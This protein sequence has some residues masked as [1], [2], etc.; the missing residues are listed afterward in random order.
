MPLRKRRAAGKTEESLERKEDFDKNVLESPSSEDEGRP[1]GAEGAA[2]PTPSSR[3]PIAQ[4]GS[5]R[6]LLGQAV[7]AV[8]V[9]TKVSG[10]EMVTVL[11]SVSFAAGLLGSVV[12]TLL[13]HAVSWAGRR[14]RGDGPGGKP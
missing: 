14:L 7:P 6:D 10:R 3:F 11:G 8:S 4:R 1:S 5:A 12:G 9:G 2:S 13:V